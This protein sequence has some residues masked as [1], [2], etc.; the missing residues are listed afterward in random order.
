MSSIT[1]RNIPEEVLARIR[2]LSARERRSI[3]SELLVLIESG[4]RTRLEL[5][6][7]SSPEITITTQLGIW[8]MLAGRWH[9]SRSTTE[10]VKEIYATRSLGRSVEL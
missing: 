9:D 10:I 4:L 6:F 7:M 5:E 1:V 8:E 3:N 2:T